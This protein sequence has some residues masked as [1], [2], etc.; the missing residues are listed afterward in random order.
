MTTADMIAI[1]AF[2]IVSRRMLARFAD[3]LETAG[4]P[5]H[6]ALIRKYAETVAVMAF[7][8]EQEHQRESEEVNA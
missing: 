7:D 3:V 6:A 2:A 1:R 8:I 5:A 4:K